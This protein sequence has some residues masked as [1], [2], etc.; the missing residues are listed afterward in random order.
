MTQALAVLPDVDR[1][2]FLMRE[3][4][5]LNYDE[6]AE[7]CDLTPDAVRSPLQRTRLQLREHLARPIAAWRTTASRRTGLPT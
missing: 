4:G 7:A 6:I 5:G 2:V 1:D 3:V